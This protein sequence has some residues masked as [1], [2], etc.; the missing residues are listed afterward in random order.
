ML[1]LSGKTEAAGGR[2][3]MAEDISTAD[4]TPRD[5]TN[6]VS[7][8]TGVTQTRSDVR[9]EL[10]LDPP[11]VVSH[12]FPNPIYMAGYSPS[13]KSI[14]V[15]D[16]AKSPKFRQRSS[17]DQDLP[18]S[19]DADKDEDPAISTVRTGDPRHA[20]K[21]EHP[22]IPTARTGDPRHADKDEDPAIPTART[23]YPRHADKDED[24]AIPTARTG[25]HHHL[26]GTAEAAAD[27]GQPIII[28]CADVDFSP[29]TDENICR[30]DMAASKTASE[31]AQTSDNNPA[32]QQKT[33][34]PNSMCVPENTIV[35]KTYLSKAIQQINSEYA[36]NTK[37]HNSCVQYAAST[38]TT[39]NDDNEKYLVPQ[40]P[41]EIEEPMYIADGST[42]EEPYAVAYG[43]QDMTNGPED[44]SS[45][46]DADQAAPVNDNANQ[47]GF[48][49]DFKRPSANLPEEA[50]RSSNT[51]PRSA[52]NGLN[53]NPTYVPNAPQHAAD[54]CTYAR[55]IAAVVMATLFAILA[56]TGASLYYFNNVGNVQKPTQAVDTAYTAGYPAV[57]TTGRAVVTTSSNISSQP[58]DLIGREAEVS[59]KAVTAPTSSIQKVVL[60]GAGVHGNVALGRPAYQ[61]SSGGGDAGLA[62]D[63]NTATDYFSQPATCTHTA[64]PAR[65]NPSW[66][67]DLGRSYMAERV[68]IFNRQD[69]CQER[70]NPFNIHIGDSDQVSENPKCGGDHHISA[71]EPSISVSCQGMKG[72]YV[73]VRLP[74][75]SRVLT[76]CEVQVFAVC[77]EPTRQSSSPIFVLGEPQRFDIIRHSI[78]SFGPLPKIRSTSTIFDLGERLVSNK[79]GH[80]ATCL[81]PANLVPTGTKKWRPDWRCG[82]FWRA[83][84]GYPAQCD[85]DGETPCC[86]GSN[87]CGNGPDHCDCRGCVDY[88]NIR[89]QGRPEPSR[90]AS[91]NVARGKN[92]YQTSTLWKKRAVAGRAVDGNT[93]A[94]FDSRSCTHTMKEGEA[95]SSWWVDLGVSFHIKTSHDQACHIGDPRPIRALIKPYVFNI[96]R[97]V[98]FNRQDCCKE[99]LNPFNIHIG[100]SDQVS[101]NPRCGGDHD[102][103]TDRPS[104]SVSCQGMKGRYVGVRLPGPSRTLSLCEVRVFSDSAHAFTHCRKVCSKMSCLNLHC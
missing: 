44:N 12:V 61:T 20:D 57:D 48:K 30:D 104:I 88:R 7:A 8:G 49:S 21:D 87:W 94:D 98:I 78:A 91:Y 83:E 58:P 43:C 51:A 18:D 60:P 70:L 59:T 42:E 56:F 33:L 86:S 96:Y 99:R 47:E 64:N 68:V 24:P 25:Q 1:G 71:Q 17:T 32:S 22:A 67:V 34:N 10:K 77:V 6:D 90:T 35:N 9:T 55:V 16:D 27:N 79:A 84:N 85:P 41:A 29:R 63:G 14:P 72:R 82:Q 28:V 102:I 4:V 101:E 40:S 53:W 89:S 103:G 80:Q 92:A 37:G 26:P 74:G 93:D 45:E 5:N 31:E 76:L 95:N 13:D 100:D 38:L 62:V 39:D 36:S 23:G 81:C 73:G 52:E 11:A 69:C 66:W 75:P 46:H 54:Q 50:G 2:L 19:M 3:N 15:K 97:V 65:P